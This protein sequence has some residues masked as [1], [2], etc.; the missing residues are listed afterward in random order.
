[1]NVLLI[2]SFQQNVLESWTSGS[3]IS[4]NPCH[5]QVLR[6]WAQ[7]TIRV[8]HYWRTIQALQ[9]SAGKPKYDSLVKLVKVLSVIPH[10]NATVE[11]GLSVAK[12]NLTDKRTNLS[13]ESVVVN[14]L[15]QSMI[16]NC[17]FGTSQTFSVG[18]TGVLG[19]LET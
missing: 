16:I 15:F 9:T 12:R 3:S 13:T 17:P 11:H 19:K 4:K 8:D 1:M 14:G 10:C 6:K 2:S 5:Q 7:R 18:A